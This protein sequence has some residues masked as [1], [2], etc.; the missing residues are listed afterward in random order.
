MAEKGEVTPYPGAV[1]DF[2]FYDLWLDTGERLLPLLR[3]Y[4]SE[5]I[6]AYAVSPMINSPSNNSPRCVESVTQ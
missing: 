4:S 3:P 5:E 1:M 2:T 6:S